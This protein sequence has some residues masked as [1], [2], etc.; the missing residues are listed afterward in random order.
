[1]SGHERPARERHAIRGL[2][3][4]LL[5]ELVL[6]A[7]FVNYFCRAFDIDRT[8]ILVHLPIVAF[9]LGASL[10]L[11][12]IPAAAAASLV[13]VLYLAD[14]ASNIE[15]GSNITYKLV[16]IWAV[17]L[18][19]G[20]NILSLS[21]WVYAGLLAV[22]AIVFAIHA[23]YR[24]TIGDG[25]R[26][27][28]RVRARGAAAVLAVAAVCYSGYFN[29]LAK[30]TSRSELLTSDPVLALMRRQ[31][32]V[33]DDTY[34]AMAAR[35]RSAE[36]A[37]R[38]AYPRH[39]P[40]DKKNVIVIIVDSLRADHMGVYGYDRPT[41]PFLSGLAA[42]GKLRRVEHATSTCAESNCGILSTLF[43]KT[44]R[45]QLPEDFKL[46]DLLKDQGYSTNFVLSGN[47]DWRDLREMYGREHTLY[48][49]GRDSKKYVPNDDRV[50][51]E[52]LDRVPASAAP[53]FFYFH[54]M[55]VHLIGSK[56]D[57]YRVYQPSNVKNDWDTLF[58]G[59][60]DRQTVINNYDNGVTQADAM[61]RQLFSA[62]D[63]KGF[64]KNGIV[65]ILADH[66]EGLGERARTGFGHVTSLYSEF[67][68][69][70]MLIYD[71]SAATYSNLSVATQIDVA[72]TILER[73][74]LPIPPTFEGRSM[75]SGSP[76]DLSFHQTALKNPC[77]AM[78][79][80]PSGRVYKYISCFLRRREEVYDLAADPGE[81]EN[82]RDSVNPA[83][84][85]FFR[86]ELARQK[87]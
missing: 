75:L 12:W 62:L 33:Y 37:A 20:G 60:Y 17:D 56:L 29:Y 55:S 13:V 18:W 65:A 42:A 68:N 32:D 79:Y 25:R 3:V 41:T 28:L 7:A 84:L 54:L 67:I 49:D 11:G 10:V 34:L 80:R 4:F 2:F 81:R 43:S 39:Q 63:A 47:H 1:M 9:I 15:T 57:D 19:H 27:L 35:I 46:Y 21:R 82:I 30:H 31:I 59:A 23:A 52:G 58:S 83:V 26:A 64:L 8:L 24:R 45:H 22:V 72:P 76:R 44:L 87:K 69:I 73:L 53:A 71:D 36:A 16:Q 51:F 48:F 74:G 50:I 77:Y 86:D 85:Q 6:S 5:V 40:F 14:F 78:V 61:I 70:P 66:G 38:A